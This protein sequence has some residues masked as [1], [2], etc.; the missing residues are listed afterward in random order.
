MAHW[1]RDY[2]P[3]PF[4]QSRMFRLACVLLLLH[5][6]YQLVRATDAQSV[7]ERDEASS[8]C[9]DG[10]PKRSLFDIIW[11][12][13]STTIICAWAAVHPNTPWTKGK[14]SEDVAATRADALDVVAPEILP[15][16]ALNQLAAMTATDIYNEENG[17]FCVVDV[18][19]VVY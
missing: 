17:I 1:P 12:C 18:C 3:D 5:L 9:V 15:C 19:Q 8:T 13:V 16:W 6:T 4:V 14:S 7:H 2:S 10:F 11:G